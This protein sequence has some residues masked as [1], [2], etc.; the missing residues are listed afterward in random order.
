MHPWEVSKHENGEKREDRMISVD[1]NN[2]G[3]R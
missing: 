3:N 1:V 2:L